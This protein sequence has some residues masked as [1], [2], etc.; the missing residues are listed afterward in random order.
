MTEL[1]LSPVKEGDYQGLLDLD[2]SYIML[3][4]LRV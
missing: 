2:S 1:G 4:S 3:Y